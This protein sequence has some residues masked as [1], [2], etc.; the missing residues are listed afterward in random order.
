MRHTPVVVPKANTSA[1]ATAK[2]IADKPSRP[3][4]D[5]KPPPKVVAVKVEPGN[6]SGHSNSAPKKRKSSD[7]D[8][9]EPEDSETLLL[10][11]DTE[12]KLDLPADEPKA[13]KQNV[14][15]SVDVAVMDVSLSFLL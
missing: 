8:L 11:L 10:D 5:L 14:V 13:K 2:L 9:F 15:K 1:Q 12:L 4:W 6:G 7:D 3:A